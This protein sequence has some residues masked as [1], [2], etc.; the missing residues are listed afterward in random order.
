MIFTKFNVLRHNDYNT[1]LTAD[2]LQLPQK[3]QRLPSC[4][5][6]NR[7]LRPPLSQRRK[8]AFNFFL[9]IN[10]MNAEQLNVALTASHFRALSGTRFQ[11]YRVAQFMILHRMRAY[12]LFERDPLLTVVFS[13]QLHF[14]FSSSTLIML[15]VALLILL[16]H[17]VR[18]GSRIRRA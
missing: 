13:P 18:K 12:A 8:A 5:D 1:L 17:E 11:A 15:I 14:A 2:P 3:Y 6:K 10:Q 9:D 4:K 16:R 7:E